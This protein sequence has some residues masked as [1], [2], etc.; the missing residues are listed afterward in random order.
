MFMQS[1]RSSRLISFLQL[2]LAIPAAAI[3]FAQ[4]QGKQNQSLLPMI[5]WQYGWV[6]LSQLKQGFD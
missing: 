6:T 5:P 1:P 2:E 4:N 3:V